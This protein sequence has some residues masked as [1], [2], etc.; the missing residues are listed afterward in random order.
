WRRDGCLRRQRSILFSRSGGTD[1]ISLGGCGASL[2]MLV[3]RASF[4]SAVNGFRPVTISYR[5]EPKLKMS[6]RASSLRP[7]ACS[8]DIYAVVPTTEPSSLAA[9]V[10]MLGE[11]SD[12]IN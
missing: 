2:T 3:S 4:V 6:D 1:A 5:T 9:T 11:G 8:G 7:S 10:V 12:S